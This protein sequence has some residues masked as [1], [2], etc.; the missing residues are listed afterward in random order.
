GVQ[1]VYTAHDF[2]LGGM[3]AEYEKVR[4]SYNIHR[5][6][7]LMIEVRPGWNLLEK[8]SKKIEQVY[9]GRPS[10]PLIFMGT[11]ITPQ[12]VDTPITIDCIAPTLASLLRIRAPN[13][14][15]AMPVPGIFK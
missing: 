12:E 7:D 10:F 4:N 13:G 2:L 5:S 1:K 6:G 3:S 15:S 11:G 9:D 8:Y 14:C